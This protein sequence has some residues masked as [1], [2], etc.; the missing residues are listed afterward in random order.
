MVN[1]SIQAEAHILFDE[2]SQQSFLTEKLANLLK[3]IVPHSSEH[4]SL[5]SFGLTQSLLQHLDSVIINLKT[6]TGHLMPILVLVVPNITAPLNNTIRTTLS[7]V[8]YLKGLPLAHSVS[9]AENFEISLL[10]GADFYWNFIGDHVVRGD[11]P[12][13]VSYRLG[14]VLSRPLSVPQSSNSV[15]SFLNVAVSHDTDAQE[16]QR[17]WKVK[18][19]GVTTKSPDKTFLEQYSNSHITQQEDGSYSTRFPW[20]DDRPPLPNNYSICQRRTLSLVHRLTQTPGM[21]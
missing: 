3:Y 6:S 16:L 1:G 18:D 4:I 14:Y 11:G 7:N 12:T 17:F 9:S 5:T 2:G 15:S 21:L 19:A 13:A 10:V 8:P 20:K